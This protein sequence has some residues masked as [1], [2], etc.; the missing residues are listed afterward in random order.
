VVSAAEEREARKTVAR[1]ERQLAKLAERETKLH[2]ELAA[3]ASDYGK[4]AEIDVKLRAVLAEK[5]ELEMDWLEA[6]EVLA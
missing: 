1:I 2:D 3:A 5:D 4:A 6:A